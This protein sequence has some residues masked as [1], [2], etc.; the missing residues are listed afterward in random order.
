MLL[1]VDML[2]V[3][4]GSVSGV[5]LRGLPVAQEIIKT[6]AIVGQDAKMPNLNCN[7]LGECNDGTMSVGYV[8]ILRR[9]SHL[10]C[11]ESWGSGTN[12]LQYIV[13]PIDAITEFVGNSATITSSLSN[14][15]SAGPAAARGKDLAIVFVNALVP[16]SPTYIGLSF[17]SG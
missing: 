2:I 16:F 3:C 6:I 7:G 14:D 12:S 10:K 13:P 5:T 9:F 4:R 1:Y 15:L 11:I 17:I 8:P